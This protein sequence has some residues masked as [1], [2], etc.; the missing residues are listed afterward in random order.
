MNDEYYNRKQS[1]NLDGSP[2]F[3]TPE[4]R[5]AEE[6]IAAKIGAAW[7]CQVR[8][9]APLCPIDWYAIRENRVVGVMEFKRRSHSVKKYPT[10]FLGVRK[11]LAL[12]LCAMGLGTTGRFIVQWTDD[13]RFI[14]LTGIDASRFV[15]SEKWRPTASAQADA[16]IEPVIEIEISAMQPIGKG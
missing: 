4:D 10:V 16:A 9:F 15:M 1:T 6:Q 12:Q 14:D 13:T 11:W 7:D 2:I 5:A 3:Q 8:H